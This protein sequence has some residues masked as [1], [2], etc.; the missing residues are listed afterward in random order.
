MMVEVDIA[1][2]SEL[3]Y[4][5]SEINHLLVMSILKMLSQAG[6]RGGTLFTGCVGLVMQSKSEL[7]YVPDP[8]C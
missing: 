4:I 8:L 5:A 7:L 1:K 2:W 6:T 3:D